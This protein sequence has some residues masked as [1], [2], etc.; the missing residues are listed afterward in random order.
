MSTPA[1]RHSLGGGYVGIDLHRVARIA[2][3]GHGG[4]VLVSGSTVAV[5]SSALPPGVTLRDMGEHRLKDLQRPEH[6]YQL[7]IDTLPAD[8][9]ALRTL[10]RTPNNLPTQLTTF[11]GRDREVAEARDLLGR[12]RLLTLTGPGGTG[13]TRLS[14]Q[15]AAEVAEE[16]PDGAFFVALDPVTDPALV[17]SAIVGAIGLQ[18][19][20]QR[21]PAERLLDFVRDRSVLLILDNFEQVLDAAPLVGDLLRASPR[22][23]IIVSS[24]AVLHVSGEQEYAVPPLG[25]PDAPETVSA[26]ARVPLSADSVA[27]I[28]AVALFVD[29]AMAVRPDFRLT[30][31]NAS[32][33]LAICRRVDGLPLAIELAAARV[34]LLPPDAILA[35]LDGRLSLLASGSRDRPERQQTLRG[36]IAWS[37]DLLG[38]GPRRLFARFSVFA[39]GAALGEAE[40]VCGPA[41]ELDEEVFDGLAALVDQSLL[42]PVE[43]TG[44]PRFQALQTIRDFAREQLDASGETDQIRERHARAFLA[45]VEAAEP[46][47]TGMEQRAW[48][49][50]LEREADNLRLALDWFVERGD[51]QSALRMG[52]AAWRFWQMRGYLFEGIQRMTAILALPGADADPVARRRGLDAAAGLTYWRGDIDGAKLLYGESL[53]LARASGDKA[54]IAEALYNESFTYMLTLIDV[55]GG[56]AM[57]AEALALF[58]ELGDAVGVARAKWDV[59]N[60]DY[61]LGNYAAARDLAQESVDEWR[62]VGDQFGLAWAHHT[63]GLSLFH[64]GDFAGARRQWVEMLRIFQAAEDVSGIGTALSNFRTLAIEA[65]DLERALRLAGASG[66][67]VMRTGVDLA[68][69][70]AQNEGDANRERTMVDEATA[71]RLLAEGAAM[72]LAQAIAYALEDEPVAARAGS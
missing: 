33:V 51:V 5:A 49:D 71:A 60:G 48:L 12:S 18:E 15:V 22:S 53:A 54:A 10:E 58:T 56:R 14:L 7:V 23:R 66:A 46:H 27:G 37:H 35:R 8:F 47:L 11:V 31:E 55:P 41:A 6:L 29:R 67:V 24:R 61:F 34:K 63:L 42:R 30:D 69:I 50:R 72:P 68:D 16:Y 40:A 70:I 62:A 21:T 57:A 20:G 28:E 43:T 36:A 26:G 19:A 4:Q 64:L 1:R 32:A 65:G 59:A 52:G 3:A 45:L 39:G 44:E 13:K 25:L 17:A 38:P 2:S 9:P